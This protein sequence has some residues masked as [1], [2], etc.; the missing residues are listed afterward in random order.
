MIYQ[1]TQDTVLPT[2]KGGTL[3][4]RREDVKC[5]FTE[6]VR[7]MPITS[8]LKRT[9]SNLAEDVRRTVLMDGLQARGHQK[10]KVF[11]A[12][13]NCFLEKDNVLI[14][15]EEDGLEFQCTNLT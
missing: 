6:D 5:L 14:T 8:L 13:F 12:Q 1:R 11:L 15:A 10:D 7:E 2:S 9:V 3:I 4:R